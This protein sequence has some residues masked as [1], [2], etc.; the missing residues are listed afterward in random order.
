MQAASEA[1]ELVGGMLAVDSPQ[2]EAARLI[3]LLE[4][5]DDER[6]HALLDARRRRTSAFI[7][8]ELDASTTARVSTNG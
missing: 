8:A 7:A 4:E 2:R 1:F 3:D 6:V 5:G